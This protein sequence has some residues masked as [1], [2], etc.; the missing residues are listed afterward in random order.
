MDIVKKRYNQDVPLEFER[1]EVQ[2]PT[3]SHYVNDLGIMA[4]QL[5]QFKG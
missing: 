5:D 1:V 3:L 4:E 2:Q